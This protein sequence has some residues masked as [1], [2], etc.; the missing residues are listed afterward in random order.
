M[1]L[2]RETNTTFVPCHEERFL[3]SFFFFSQ[4]QLFLEMLTSLQWV[5]Y[6]QFQQAA[7]FGT[8]I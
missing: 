4:V 1:V 3:F 8:K 7:V 2:G 6:L 5:S